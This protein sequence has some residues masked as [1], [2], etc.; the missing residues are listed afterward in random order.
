[1]INKTD[2]YDLHAKYMKKKYFFWIQQ[3]IFGFKNCCGIENL[4]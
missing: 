2:L 4:D 1:M 3:Q